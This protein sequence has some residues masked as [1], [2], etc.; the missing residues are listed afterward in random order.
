MSTMLILRHIRIQNANAL[1]SPYTIGFPAM[2]AWLGFTHALQRKLRDRGFA[3]EF[4]GTGVVSHNMALQTYKGPNDFVAS[5]IGTGNPLDPKSEKDNVQ[6]AVR[7]SFIE[8]AR[9]HLDVSLVIAVTGLSVDERDDFCTSVNK[10][11]TGSMK[12]A[13]GDIFD[14]YTPTV[15]NLND[16]DSDEVSRLFRSLMP[17]YALIER[18]ELMQQA[19][20]SGQ[21]A[22]DAMLDYLAVHHHCHKDDK[23]KVT[24]SSARK[25][26]PLPAEDIDDEPQPTGWIVPVAVGFQG[27]TPLAESLNRRDTDTP[28]RFA[29]SVVT[30]GE[31][32]MVYRL[33]SIG[34]LLWH[35]HYDEANT[36][37]LCEQQNAAHVHI[38]DSD[39]Y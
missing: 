27:L 33:N 35:Y 19:M 39:L 37:Y 26:A 4:D 18:R 7:P 14:F 29:E 12:I 34:Q 20:E 9:C 11:L 30:L 36:L 32:R 28:H 24:W 10:L 13:G 23:G 15:V 22:L 16:T 5:I 2:T 3:V 38:D 17:G 1:S 25:S 8:E 31:F 21:D 6:N